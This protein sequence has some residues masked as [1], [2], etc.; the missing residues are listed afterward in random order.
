MN[1]V[2]VALMELVSRV[3]CV[4]PGAEWAIKQWLP[5]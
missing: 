5:V 1:V 2:L 4:L 3:S